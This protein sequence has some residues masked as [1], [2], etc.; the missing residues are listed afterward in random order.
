MPMTNPPPFDWYQFKL[1]L[2]HS[3]G[4]SMD[5]LHVIAGVLIQL[6]VAALFRATVARPLPLIVVFLLE[7]LNEWNDLRVEQW[8]DAGMQY[9]EGA[10]DLLL[11]ML[12]PVLLFLVA[13]NRPKLIR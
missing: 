9:G 5:A 10:K 2:E 6:A 11:T 8:P 13:R 1:F 12:L 7:L 4:F 3:A